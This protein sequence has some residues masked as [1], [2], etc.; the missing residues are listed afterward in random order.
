MKRG[1]K[2]E[3]KSPLSRPTGK[4]EDFCGYYEVLIWEQKGPTV[5]RDN[6]S[7]FKEEGCC[8]FFRCFAGIVPEA[9]PPGV[10]RGQQRRSVVSF[11]RKICPGW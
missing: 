11:G 7:L 10:R 4:K 1:R 3:S 9:F 5:F 8:Y 6:V 2:I